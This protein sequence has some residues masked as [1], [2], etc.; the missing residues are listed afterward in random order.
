M[1]LEAVLRGQPCV[2]ALRKLARGADI[3]DDLL[4]T[5][6]KELR[7]LRK[8]RD[9]VRQEDEADRQW[10]GLPRQT[11]GALPE[12]CREYREKRCDRM[13]YCRGVVEGIGKQ[14]GAKNRFFGR[15]VFN[16]A[17]ETLQANSRM[18]LSRSRDRRMGSQLR[19]ENAGGRV[20]HW[21][22]HEQNAVARM[23]DER[24]WLHELKKNGKVWD[25]GFERAKGGG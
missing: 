1:T 8:E 20:R 17:I 13:G 25:E 2:Q 9:Y 16:M 7:E 14:W 15:A 6:D 23:A 11:F 4:D 18:R 19:M 5:F 22:M 21:R 12:A 3:I 10:M 24:W